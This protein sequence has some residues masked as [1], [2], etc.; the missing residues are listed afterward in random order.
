MRTKV[1]NGIPVR[2]SFEEE[3]YEMLAEELY[4]RVK[5]IRRTPISVRAFL[6]TRKHGSLRTRSAYVDRSGA[7]RLRA[8]DMA[9]GRSRTETGNIRPTES[10][11]RGF[12][13]RAAEWFDADFAEVMA[14]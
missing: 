6:D 12:V 3:M 8:A 2:M 11:M 9:D 14:Q 10:E 7:W 5:D 1:I 13:N 4:P